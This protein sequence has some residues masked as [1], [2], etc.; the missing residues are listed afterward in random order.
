MFFGLLP[1]LP[2][3]HSF[4]HK[5]L[6]FVE[7]AFQKWDFSS[8]L[9]SSLGGTAAVMG[10]LIV[11]PFLANFIIAIYVTTWRLSE[12]MG[13]VC[14]AENWTKKNHKL[15][16]SF[17][18]RLRVMLYLCPDAASWTQLQEVT[19]LHPLPW[20][21]SFYLTNFIQIHFLLRCTFCVGLFCNYST[22]CVWSFREGP[23]AG[24]DLK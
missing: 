22:P 17:H 18:S 3:K 1:P 24:F 12:M 16:V 7:A 14:L 19:L 11:L 20:I 8:L 21:N 9:H 2:S 23:A 6:I 4:N 15:N 13:N 10:H 5:E